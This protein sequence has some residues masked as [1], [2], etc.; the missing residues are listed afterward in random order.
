MALL[1]LVCFKLGLN[2]PASCASVGSVSVVVELLFLLFVSASFS[3]LHSKV[4][5][6]CFISVEEEEDRAAVG[7][8]EFLSIAFCAAEECDECE[9]SAQ[10]AV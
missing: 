4:V 6:F 5:V 8:E 7:E 2:S 9:M 10:C 3:L 1:R